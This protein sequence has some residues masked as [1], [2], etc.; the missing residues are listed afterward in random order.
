[1][2]EQQFVTGKFKRKCGQVNRPQISPKE[3]F[4]KT[5]V[6]KGTS[7]SVPTDAGQT[8]PKEP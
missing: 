4:K 6:D 1:M 7:E 5:Q 8:L 3:L 2:S